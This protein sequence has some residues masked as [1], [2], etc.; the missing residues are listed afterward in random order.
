LLTRILSPLTIPVY[1][2]KG[3][4]VGFG[5]PH[6]ATEMVCDKVTALDPP[7]H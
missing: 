6:G 4:E 3:P 5:N 7:A 2:Q 1:R